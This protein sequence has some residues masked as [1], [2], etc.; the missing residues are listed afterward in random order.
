M[1]TSKTP[2]SRAAEVEL[3]LLVDEVLGVSAAF[4]GSDLYDDAVHGD[5]SCDAFQVHVPSGRFSR[6]AEREGHEHD[7]PTLSARPKRARPQLQIPAWKA[8]V[9]PRG[10]P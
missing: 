1:S 6:E 10:C 7:E 8:K 9:R 5:V 3:Q 2:A 4:R